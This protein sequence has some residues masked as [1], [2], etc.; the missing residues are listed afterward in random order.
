MRNGDDGSRA[1]RATVSILS[2]DVIRA[3]LPA[4][5]PRGFLN[6]PQGGPWNG[7]WSKCLL[8]LAPESRSVSAVGGRLKSR[9]GPIHSTYSVPADVGYQGKVSGHGLA[10][11][12]EVHAAF[13]RPEVRGAPVVRCEC[14]EP[15]RA[16][17]VE[18]TERVLLI[19]RREE[20]GRIRERNPSAPAGRKSLQ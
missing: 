16:G 13:G 12:A 15:A 7:A 6:Q 17:I 14:R 18:F 3:L 11:L 9:D 5:N 1:H 8:G 10:A 4:E 2:W 20:M 19:F